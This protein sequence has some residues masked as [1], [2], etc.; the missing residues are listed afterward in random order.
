MKNYE[1]IKSFDELIEA[2]HGKIGTESRNKYE[3]NSQMFIISE[4]LKEAISK[5]LEETEN[6]V[7]RLDKIAS[8]LGEKLTGKTCKA[9]KGLIEEGSEVMEEEYEIDALCDALMIGA[10]Q[11]IEHYEMAGYGTA[12]AIAEQLGETEVASLL[13][14]TLDEEKAADEKLSEISEQEVLMEASGEDES[15]QESEE[16]EEDEETPTRRSKSESGSSQR[17]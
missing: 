14:E 4:M 15:D 12:R 7:A 17:R 3:E 16:E 6:H 13:Q 8:I 2:E 1:N 9:M 10:A 5:H 11:R